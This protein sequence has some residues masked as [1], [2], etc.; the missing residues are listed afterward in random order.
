MNKIRLVCRYPLFFGLCG[1]LLAGCG[2]S[3]TVVFATNTNL[4]VGFD[5]S[6]ATGLIG[7]Q[8]QEASI[9]PD[10]PKTGGIPPVVASLQ[11]SQSF[12]APSVTQYYATGDAA[13]IATKRI[14]APSLAD[15][16]KATDLTDAE[17]C[18]L[19]LGCL[20]DDHHERRVSV[21]ATNTHVGLQIKTQ[22]GTLSSLDFGYGRQE[23][24]VLPLLSK[25]GEDFYPSSYASIVVDPSKD[26][27]GVTNGLAIS[28]FFATGAAADALAG[29]SDV[30]KSFDGIA[31][32]A[33]AQQ[34]ASL[35]T[36]LKMTDS[37][38]V[39][40]VSQGKQ[41]ARN[42]SALIDAALKKLLGR[43]VGDSESLTPADVANIRTS[44]NTL[45]G[46]AAGTYN[47]AAA[48]LATGGSYRRYLARND[49]AAA[50]FVAQ[51]K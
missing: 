51:Q 43:V 17:K 24:S 19:N 30:Q 20:H 21:V 44:L 9:G 50:A 48:D 6:S 10:Y 46:I 14:A 4:A 31:S 22:T 41:T 1:I 16:K 15:R 36:S 28:Q 29:T 47:P 23:A 37:Q 49:D 2:S 25:D 5:A 32:A 45:P 26:D 42:N 13:L 40:L 8:R 11:S 34:Q 18:S 12:F 33:A 35:A 39:A 7:Y 38:Y 3:D 27:K